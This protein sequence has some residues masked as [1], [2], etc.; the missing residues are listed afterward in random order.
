MSLIRLCSA[1]SLLSFAIST[2]ASAAT[3]E[4]AID[5][6]HTHVGFAVRHIFS[7]LPG[8]FREFDG[9]IQWDAQNPERSTGTFTA[10]AAS[11]NTGVDKRDEHLRSQD[12]FWAEKHPDLILNVKKLN[13]TADPGKYRAE[14]DLTMRGMTKPV[15]LDVAYLG[16]T[17]NPW[18]QTVVALEARGKVNRSD[19]EL[20][21]N[22]A[23]EGGKVL[24][25]EEIELVLD[26]EANEKPAEAKPAKADGKAKAKK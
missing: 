11:I 1:V 9:T 15:V 7:R 22:K 23:L 18:G 24:V 19:W 25:G 17:K 3:T 10:K 13:K 21:W 4:L 14:A 26:V 16:T 5:K 20:M 12:F 8:T 2:V 6:A